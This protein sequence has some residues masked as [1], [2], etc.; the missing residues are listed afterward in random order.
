MANRNSW[1]ASNPHNELVEIFMKYILRL[2]PLGFLMENVQGILWTPNAGTSVSVVDVIERRLKGAGYVLF[3]KLLDD[4]SY[5]VP[6]NRTRFFLMGLHRDL[7]YSAE[8][9][10][11][12]GPFPRPSHGDQSRPFVTVRQAIADLPR[13]GNGESEERTLYLEPSSEVL[14]ENEFLRYARA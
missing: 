3:A 7:G 2:R 14:H 6:Q 13:I 11:S 5:G 10:G 9:F 12:W 4:V 8:D 1:S